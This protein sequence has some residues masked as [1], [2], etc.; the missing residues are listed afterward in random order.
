[1]LMMLRAG[2]KF[3]LFSNLGTVNQ[4]G[5]QSDAWNAEPGGAILQSLAA[6]ILSELET[7]PKT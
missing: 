6:D 2:A 4:I 1:M 3:P 7:A 5:L